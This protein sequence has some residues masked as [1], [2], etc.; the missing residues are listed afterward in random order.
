MRLDSLDQVR[1]HALAEPVAAD[2]HRHASRL[3][4]EVQNGLAGGVSGPDDD[5]VLA[6]ALSC[7]AAACAVVHAVADEI[8]DA[9][10]VEP[11]PIHSR[12]RE[13]HRRRH[14]GAVLENHLY[15]LIVVRSS[16]CRGRL[17]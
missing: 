4:R 1:G 13:H 12:S 16:G 15:R 5:D 9:V 6:G 7:L 3:V 2:E 10:Q 8:V 11:G 17:A 14:L